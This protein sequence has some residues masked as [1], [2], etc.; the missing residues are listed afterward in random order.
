MIHVEV[1][2]RN[3]CPYCQRAKDLLASKGINYDEIDIS[4]DETMAARMMRL[5]GQ[6]NAPQIFINNRAIGGYNALLQLNARGE[7]NQMLTI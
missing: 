3:D 7:L 5:S 6:R 2:S 4:Y 1:F